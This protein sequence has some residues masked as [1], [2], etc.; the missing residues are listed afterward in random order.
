MS[1]FSR[2]MVRALTLIS[3]AFSL[4]GCSGADVLNLTIPR[5]GYRVTR[6]VSYGEES[7]QML[8]IYTPDGAHHA[9]VILF[10]YGGSW[11]WGSKN[12]YR[13]LGQAFASKGYVTVVA[14]YRLYPQVHF[15]AFV[16][17]SARALAF[18]HAH[19][20]D[21][22]GDANNLFVAGHSA[23]AFN[24]VMLT[25]NVR[26][27]HEAGANR[28]WI[29]GTIGIAGPYDFLP[30]TD[31]DIIAVFSQAA[32][33][34]TQPIN[35]VQGALPPFLLA[36]GKEDT[37]VLPRNST[38]LA[39]ALRDNHTPVE[40]HQYDRVA[41]IG[42]VLSLARGFRSKAPLLEDIAAFIETHRARP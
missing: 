17:D 3:G 12:D 13:F 11:Q 28:G 21:Y 35:F 16:H 18:V 29:R 32:P 22:G 37:T 10:F 30:L 42:I 27:L 9:P 24:A 5:D 39:E 25:L 40:L 41:H 7:R 33:A 36:V 8:D 31:T 34:D 26:Y 15:P 2:I 23:G 6:D 14:D 20:G 4:V 19:I 38:H 1:A